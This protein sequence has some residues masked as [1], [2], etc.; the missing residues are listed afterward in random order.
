M[1][2]AV[3]GIFS[4]QQGE[5]ICFEFDDPVFASNNIGMPLDSQEQPVG[6]ISEIVYRTSEVLIDVK[7]QI[8][9]VENALIGDVR[10]MEER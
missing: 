4:L 9:F 1:C 8:T 10:P 7:V 3:N 6:I 5:D 2:F